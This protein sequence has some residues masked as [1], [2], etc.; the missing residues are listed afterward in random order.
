MYKRDDKYFLSREEAFDSSMRKS[1]HYIETLRSGKIKG[2]PDAYFYRTYVH[3]YV[4]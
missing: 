2:R 4:A 3:L 1:I